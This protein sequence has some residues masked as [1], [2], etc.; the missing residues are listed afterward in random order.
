MWFERI[1]AE[2]LSH[3]SYMIGSAGKSA[4]I[5]P[6]RDCGIYVELANRHD[7]VITHIF[8][9]HRNEDYVT[10]APELA[11]RC[12]AKICHGSHMDFAFGNKVREND[13]FTIGTL[14]LVVL[15]TPGHTEESITLVLAD[16]EVS[17]DPW[18]VFTGDTIFAGEIARTD[19]YGQEKKAEM[20]EKIYTSITEKILT[21]GDG[22]IVCPAH[23]AGSAC[24][25]EIADHP[26]TTVGYEKRTNPVLALGKEAFVSRRIAESPYLPQYFRQMETVNKEGPALLHTLLRVQPLTVPSV[27]AMIASGC[28]VVDIRSPTAFAAGHI[29]GSLS[30]WREGIAAF[31]G[32]FLDYEHPI[33]LVD[34]FN[35]DLK[36][37]FRHFMRMG[38]DNTAGWLAGG[39]AAWYRAAEPVGTV[40]ACAVQDAKERLTRENVFLL[41]VRDRKNREHAGFIPGSHHI[42]VGELPQ[43]LNEI[44][45]N[46]PVIVYCDSGF[47][48]SLAVSVLALHGSSDVTNVLGGMQ[49][50]ILAG[51]PVGK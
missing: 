39:F 38:Y 20:A 25:G 2:G 18:M 21:L 5:D 26:F 29:P 37:A 33:I 51:Y 49:A 42:Y 23:G 28:Q 43:H 36:T 7:A 30:I 11:H 44:P 6:R 16:T 31:A 50:W 1:V 46:Q 27:K 12:G 40:G 4:V 32:G 3:N 8:E 14:E 48:G 34:D 45:K 24:G 10:G 41:D 19:F 9:T 15:E 35:C 47:K 17:R 22:V 13:R